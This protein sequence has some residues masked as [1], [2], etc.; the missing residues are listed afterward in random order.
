MSRFKI[1]LTLIF[2]G[3]NLCF[4][5]NV[6]TD[7]GWFYVD[8]KKFF[9]KGIGYETNARP[10]HLPWVYSF[11]PDIIAFD[12]ERI[13]EAGFNTIRT[14]AALSEEEL[15]LIDNTGIKVLMGI[16]IDPAG[17]FQDPAFISQTINHVNE[18]LNYSKNYECI[19]GYLIMNEPLVE[20]I[21]ETGALSLLELWESVIEIIHNKHP[22]APVSFA[23]TVIGDYI[24]MDIF[25]FAGYNAYNYSTSSFVHSHQFGNYLEYLKNNRASVMPMI[26]TEHGLSVSPGNI[27]PGFTYGLNTP[28]QQSE[29]DL[30][31]YRKLIDA[32]ATGGCVFQYHDGWWKGGDEFTHNDD[33]EEWFGLIGFS[34]INDLYGTPRK[35]WEDLSVYNRAI[36]T[37]PKNGVFYE[38]NIPVEIFADEIITHFNME[39]NDSVV[40]SGA[41]ED[42]LYNGIY[43]P[44]NTGELRDLI[45]G[46]S[47]Y[48]SGDTLLKS[49]QISVLSA[50]DGITLPSVTIELPGEVSAGNM[51]YVSYKLDVNSPFTI[52]E[53]KAD[54]MA[55]PHIGFNPGTNKTK[56]IQ[57]SNNQFSFTDNFYIPGISRVVTFGAGFTIKYGNFSKRI[58]AE[59]IVLIGDWAN[60]IASPELLTGIGRSDSEKRVRDFQLFQNYPNP[61]NPA[62]IIRYSLPEATHVILKVYNIIG[63]EITT[64]VNENKSPGDYRVTWDA[65]NNS[66]GIY[67]YQITAGEYSSAR[68]CIVIR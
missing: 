8:G 53:D 52:V 20:H 60:P 37:S 1:I 55:Q 56:T 23:N 51:V 5:Q 54:Y 21:Y 15:Q 19:I 13:K 28:E 44:Q 68:K 18:V 32:G 12:M 65:E 66:S 29:C 50:P 59:K 46:F 6:R 36:I 14:W 4:P 48:D 38:N 17:N 24:N 11:D 33:P 2:M 39:L 64:L 43:L 49:E 22:E 25:D 42:G 30:D 47:F 10:G 35:A 67:I 16:W 27:T 58:S 57:L 41:I 62:T 7:E 3:L 31:S 9:V 26:I 63:E 40:M 61:F 34:D 45:L